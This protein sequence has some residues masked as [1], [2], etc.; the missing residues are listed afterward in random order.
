MTVTG[1]N[2]QP[3]RG[4]SHVSTVGRL[5]AS[6]VSVKCGDEVRT[7]PRVGRRLPQVG[8]TDGHR[9]RISS[10]RSVLQDC[11]DAL[12]RAAS[13]ARPDAGREVCTNSEKTHAQI[14]RH[15]RTAVFRNKKNP[16]SVVPEKINSPELCYG[17]TLFMA[18]P[19]GSGAAE[20]N[21]CRLDRHAVLNDDGIGHAANALEILTNKVAD[22]IHA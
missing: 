9:R 8:G 21:G 3:P 12:T 4:Q 14:S 22:A 10:A 20:A 7:K 6:L 18:I 5:P 13:R 17:E 11:R 2:G 15:K 16:H 1:S 19:R